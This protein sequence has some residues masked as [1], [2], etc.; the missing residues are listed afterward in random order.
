MF[1]RYISTLIIC[2]TAP[3]LF[4]QHIDIDKKALSFL[5]SQK[6]MNIVFVQDSLL[7]IDDVYETEFIQKMRK[8]IIR[9]STPE[10]A[11]N[12][13]SAYKKN[14]D[15]IWPEIFTTQ[16][17]E[18]IGEYKNAPHFEMDNTEATYT[19]KITPS[20]MY[21]GYDIGI[22]DRPAKVTLQIYFYE[23][24]NPKAVIFSTEISRAMA[25]YNMRDG[26]GEGAGPSLNRMRKAYQKAAYKLAKALKRVVD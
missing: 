10:E 20:W 11:S 21:F 19:L 23:T 26:D 14:K 25:K 12:W 17:N 1:K 6:E 13:I 22:I 7:M 24:K 18:K 16:L 2:F 8:K 9:Q 5:A 3:F 15:E 4:A